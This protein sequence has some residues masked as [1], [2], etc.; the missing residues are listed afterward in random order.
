MDRP[1]IA[2]LDDATGPE[3]ML[4]VHDVADEILHDRMDPEGTSRFVRA[5]ME[6]VETCFHVHGPTPERDAVTV[7]LAQGTDGNDGAAFVLLMGH[8]CS[9]VGGVLK[10][11]AF[12]DEP[13]IEF[14]HRTDGADLPATLQA[15]LA[16]ARMVEFDHGADDLIVGSDPDW[17]EAL[18]ERLQTLAE[19]M[20][21]EPRAT[22][23]P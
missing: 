14:R 15:R 17:I 8:V 11:D 19:V 20:R 7:E 12:T 23:G 10:S 4:H 2:V 16:L 21:D 3:V 9:R 1:T 6:G 5:R 18:A 22:P 13:M